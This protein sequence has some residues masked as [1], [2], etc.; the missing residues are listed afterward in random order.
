MEIKTDKGTIE[1]SNEVF[2]TIC[3][4]A[5][6]NCF[7]VKGMA[8]RTVTDGLVHLL[9]KEAMSKG[10]KVR[11]DA[12]GKLIVELHI[13]VEYGVNI[14]AISRAIISEVTYVVE[15]LTGVAVSQVD[16]CVDSI[17]KSE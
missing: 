9:K 10:V 16:I 12:D 15:R 17:M 2:T 13:I 6:T 8:I 11:S 4:C 7:G 1:I 3:G 14:A 5:A